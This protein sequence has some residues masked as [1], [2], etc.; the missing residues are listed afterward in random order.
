VKLNETVT[1][2]KPIHAKLGPTFKRDAKEI[3]AYLSSLSGDAIATA[4]SGI[5]VPMSD[6]RKISLG[7][8]FYDVVKT[9]SSERGELNHITAGGLSV[10]MYK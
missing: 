3:V 8:E 2:V 1:G 9:I 7:R 6:G 5:E 10:L 4:D